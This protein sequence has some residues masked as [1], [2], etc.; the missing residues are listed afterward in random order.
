MYLLHCIRHGFAQHNNLFKTC[1]EKAYYMDECIDSKLLDEGIQQAVD[2]HNNELNTLSNCDVVFVSPLFRTL[3][4]AEILFTGLD[5]KIIV[6]DILKEYPNGLQKVNCRKN[7]SELVK[8]FLK[9]DFSNINE[10]DISWNKDELET[11]EELDKRISYF[12]NKYLGPYFGKKICI[13]G[14]NSFL[15]KLLLNRFEEMEH[16]KIYEKLVM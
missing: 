11:E 2:L 6:C 1:G 9:F 13:I 3:Q 5:T 16:C 10:E 4:T 15:S 12:K 14:H 7:K 8:R